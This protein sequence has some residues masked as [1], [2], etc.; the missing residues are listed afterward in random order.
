MK[1]GLVYFCHERFLVQKF[2]FVHPRYLSDLFF[3]DSY[4][5]AGKC[6]IQTVDSKT[7]KTYKITPCSSPKPNLN[8]L[9]GQ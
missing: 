2:Q 6:S 4:E 3:Q 8:F 5:L 9:Y 1:M 7:A